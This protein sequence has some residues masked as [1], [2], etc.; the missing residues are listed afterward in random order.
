MVTE[1]E[2]VP[3]AVTVASFVPPS[4][5][6][7]PRPRTAR[8]TPYDLS[9]FTCSVHVRN[10]IGNNSHIVAYSKRRTLC[11]R[12]RHPPF[13]VDCHNV[14]FDFDVHATFSFGLISFRRGTLT[15]RGSSC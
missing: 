1:S 13:T 10:V 2:L 9:K 3:V 8:S 6:N 7:D 14:I 12:L 5:F 15:S 11:D 4:K